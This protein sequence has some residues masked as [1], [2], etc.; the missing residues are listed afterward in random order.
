[1]QIVEATI[2]EIVMH[3]PEGYTQEQWLEKAG[4]TC[5]KSE[6][7]ITQ[8]SAPKFIRMLRDRGHLAMIEHSMASAIIAAD[9]GLTHELVRHRIASFAQEST[10][11]CNYSKG[12]FNGE[13][14]VIK[15]PWVGTEEEIAKAERVHKYAARAAERYYNTLL[16]LGQPPQLARAVLPIS[17]RSEIVISANLR[18]WMH[19]F[20]MRTDT[21][22]HPIIRGCAL[23][24]LDEMNKRLPS[25]YEVLAEKYLE[26][27]K[28]L[29]SDY[30][31]LAEKYLEN[32]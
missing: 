8:E 13:I 17:L 30:E 5:Y 4:R 1:M 18:E 22:A 19:V 28:D 23:R 32:I 25:V 3:L 26:G 20:K 7:K 29:M 12:K 31:V 14:T 24:I 6:D 21:P 11:Y 9:R 16:K 10:R 2:K 27:N 15:Y